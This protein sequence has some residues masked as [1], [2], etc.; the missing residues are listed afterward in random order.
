VSIPTVSRIVGCH[1]TL[2]FA[3]QQLTSVTP[4]G[5]MRCLLT[6]KLR[7]DVFELGTK[8]QRRTKIIPNYPIS[9]L[10]FAML[11]KPAMSDH[12]VSEIVLFAVVIRFG[13]VGRVK[14]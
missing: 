4:D 12:L 13:S 10:R 14:W 3:W 6:Q 1:W 8:L 5:A 11:S 7:E 2:S 9:A